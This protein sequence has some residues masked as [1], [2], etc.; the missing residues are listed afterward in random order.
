M[1]LEELEP[2]GLYHALRSLTMTDFHYICVNYKVFEG[3][4]SI[5][6]V[7]CDNSLIFNEIAA[8]FKQK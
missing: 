2:N 7:F 1:L 4:Q 8:E 3:W 6:E 5:G